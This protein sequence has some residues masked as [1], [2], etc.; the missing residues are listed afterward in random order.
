MVCSVLLCHRNWLFYIVPSSNLYQ[1]YRKHFK[2]SAFLLKPAMPGLPCATAIGRPASGLKPKC[3]QEVSRLLSSKVFH[4]SYLHCPMHKSPMAMPMSKE[5][6]QKKVQ[7]SS[8]EQ[9]TFLSDSAAGRNSK[10]GPIK[11]KQDRNLSDDA[12]DW[13]AVKFNWSCMRYLI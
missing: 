2:T 9:W 6:V 13:T 5:G 7:P 8:M 12:L 10:L 3:C 4:S 11:D 1:L